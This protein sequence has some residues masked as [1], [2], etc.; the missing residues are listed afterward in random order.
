MDILTIALDFKKITL[1]NPVE[2]LF[3]DQ[4]KGILLQ[5]LK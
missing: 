2:S 1:E 5:E 4:S 3:A